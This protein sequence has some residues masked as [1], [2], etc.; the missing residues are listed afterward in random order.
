M[1]R[2]YFLSFGMILQVV[3]IELMHLDIAQSSPQ[4]LQ[5]KLIIRDGRSRNSTILRTFCSVI[6]QGKCN[7]LELMILEVVEAKTPID[8]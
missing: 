2:I 4:C 7:A 8:Y 6:T 3:I 1:L 5:N